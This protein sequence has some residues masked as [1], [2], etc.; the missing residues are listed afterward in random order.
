MYYWLLF[1][2][3]ALAI[4]VN[5]PTLTV[6]VFSANNL[7]SYDRCYVY[8]DMETFKMHKIGFWRGQRENMLGIIYTIA[9]IVLAILAFF[10]ANKWWMALVA[11]AGGTVLRVI[12]SFFGRLHYGSFLYFVELIIEPVLLFFAYYFLIAAHNPYL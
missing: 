3:P 8:L 9:M 2:I 5:L 10:L 12:R 1:Y 7:D 4:A 6:K 11:F